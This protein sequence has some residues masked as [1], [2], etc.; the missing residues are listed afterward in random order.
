MMPRFSL[1]ILFFLSIVTYVSTSCFPSRELQVEKSVI[2]LTAIDTVYRAD[3]SR[4]KLIW[5][6]TYNKVEYTEFL[7]A[8]DLQDIIGNKK[9]IYVIK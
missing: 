7:K 9:Y 5:F 1:S 6:D 2:E 4:V 8:N 3:G